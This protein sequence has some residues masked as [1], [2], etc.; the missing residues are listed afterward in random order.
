MSENI[1]CLQKIIFESARGL[2]KSK[3]ELKQKAN[4]HKNLF[5]T[6]EMKISKKA[7]V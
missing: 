7:S 5:G 4:K 3:W 2:L 1:I 6:L